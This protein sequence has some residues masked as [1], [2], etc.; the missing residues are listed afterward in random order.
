M[1]LKC[2]HC[3]VEKSKCQSYIVV[4]ET[5]EKAETSQAAIPVP[6]FICA[7]KFH[8]RLLY[9]QWTS[10]AAN[11]VPGL[12]IKVT[13]TS[14]MS[15]RLEKHQSRGTKEIVHIERMHLPGYE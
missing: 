2:K 8:E 11:C 7:S 6:A 3:V 15:K 5:K 1:K 10:S 12:S 4:C 14:K 9:S 13:C